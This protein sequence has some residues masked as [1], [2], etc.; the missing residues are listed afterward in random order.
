MSPNSRHVPSSVHV[1]GHLGGVGAGV[2]AD[3][4]AGVGTS[5]PTVDAAVVPGSAPRWA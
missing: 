5:G 4:G 3:V 2:G 1:P